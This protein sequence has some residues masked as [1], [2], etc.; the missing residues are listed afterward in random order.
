MQREGDMVKERKH[1]TRVKRGGSAHADSQSWPLGLQ[2][3]YE[4][5]NRAITEFRTMSLVLS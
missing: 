4:S 5:L 1:K 3:M 2:S